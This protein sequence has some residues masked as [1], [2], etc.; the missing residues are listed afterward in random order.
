MLQALAD[1]KKTGVI[2]GYLENITQGEKFLQVAE[3]TAAHK[4]VVILK[5]GT[6]E[7]GAKAASSHTGSLAGTDVTYTAAFKHSGVVRAH[8]I[9]QLFDYAL[10]LG[11][12][13]L[14]KGNRVAIITNAGGPGIMAADAAEGNGF[15]LTAPTK[16]SDEKLR[17]FLPKTAA[18]GNPIDVIGDADPERYLKTFKV[19][20]D[21]DNSDAIVVLVTPQNMTQPLELAKELA[22]ANKKEKPVLTSFI[23][24][25]AVESAKQHLMDSGIPNYPTPERALQ[26]LKVMYD[27]GAW[28]NRPTRVVE[29]FP[30]NRRRVER[31]LSKYVRM[32]SKQVIEVDAKSI[33]DAYGFSTL[34]GGLATSN[35]EAIETAERIGFPVVMKI[36]SSDIIHKSD[37]GG[38]R[39]NLGS[40]EQ[41]RDAYDLIITRAK[42]NAPDAHIQGVYVEKMGRPG[43]EVILGLTRDP[44]F[45]PMLMFGLGGIF[46]EVL[47]DVAFQ[48]APITAD[49]AMQML[50]LTRSYALLKGARRQA[51]VDLE[52]IA[53]ALQRISQLSTDYPEISELDIN[54]FIVGE[55]GK[56]AYVADARITLDLS[57]RKN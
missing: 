2:V 14:P 48:L 12:Q 35:Q 25:D 56:D 29:R 47:K 19:I 6:T 45:G 23:G 54:P 40:A 21:D 8:N 52:S 24:G 34:P 37:L 10:A 46:V 31:I 51:P 9:E 39:I 30:V 15:K 49:E 33:L 42:Q 16:A 55:V 28:R 53:N 44:Q 18:F 27:Y 11:S 43:R 26:T 41:V 32:K 3:Q 17:T 50:K 1:D 13:P 4:P 38:V 20:Q 22:N 5:A 36:V 57:S 7:A